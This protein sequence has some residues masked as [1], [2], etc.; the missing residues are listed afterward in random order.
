MAQLSDEAKLALVMSLV[1]SPWIFSVRETPW[2]LFILG[3]IAKKFVTDRAYDELYELTAEDV[4]DL[5]SHY[6][7]KETYEI[8]SVRYWVMVVP[9]FFPKRLYEYI[10]S[11]MNEENLDAVLR[12]LKD[13]VDVYTL[14]LSVSG[15]T[16]YNLWY[17]VLASLLGGMKLAQEEEESRE[18]SVPLFENPL[19]KKGKKITCQVTI[20][21]M[22]IS[23]ATTDPK[24]MWIIFHANLFID[25]RELSAYSQFI[26]REEEMEKRLK[27]RVTYLAEKVHEWSFLINPPEH[28]LSRLMKE[29]VCEFF[30]SDASLH[31]LGREL[32]IS[33]GPRK[34]SEFV[35]RLL[36]QRIVCECMPAVV[37][38][39]AYHGPRRRFDTVTPLIM[40]GCES[41]E[42]S[43]L[44]QFSENIASPKTNPGIICEFD[45]VRLKEHYGVG[46]G[47]ALAMAQA[48]FGSDKIKVPRE[49]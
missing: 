32:G 39:G 1:L 9:K 25:D 18:F 13:A 3:Q 30:A 4:V 15:K 29:T 12:V 27:E 37:W 35:Y 19:T 24:H 48:L 11:G 21:K 41:Y 2:R 43:E 34:T 6:V 33:I 44:I 17:G 23:H 14:K 46:D 20:D 49:H 31:M 38:L 45:D 28:I 22:W 8:S 10:T 16:S 5:I 47:G 26:T 7:D 36:T 42:I 40:D